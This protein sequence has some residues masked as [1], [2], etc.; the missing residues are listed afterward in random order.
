MGGTFVLDREIAGGRFFSLIS[1]LLSLT[2]PRPF[3]SLDFPRE[4]CYTLVTQR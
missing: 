1:S 4:I 3:L 2:S